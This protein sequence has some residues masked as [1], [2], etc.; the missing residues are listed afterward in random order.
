MDFLDSGCSG[1]PRQDA[2]SSMM[3]RVG[4]SGPVTGSPGM[5]MIWNPADSLFVHTLSCGGKAG[6]ILRQFQVLWS[7]L[8]SGAGD[9]IDKDAH[10]EIYTGRNCGYCRAAKA[11]LDARGLNYAETDITLNEE[12]R[13]EMMERSQRR[14]I[15]QIFI[16]G[17]SIGGFVE[18][19]QLLK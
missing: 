2:G 12:K 16:D 10:I 8:C 13:L 9:M 18:L 17:R 6:K 5:P 4:V 7:A 14:T 3:S 11:L 1:K 15:P 19:T